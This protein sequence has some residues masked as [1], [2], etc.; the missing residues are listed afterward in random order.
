MTKPQQASGCDVFFSIKLQFKYR[1]QK[2]VAIVIL[3]LYFFQFLLLHDTILNC[4][5]FICPLLD[6]HFQELF[7]IKQGQNLA[8][9]A[10]S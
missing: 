5:G 10:C 7:L 3:N 9:L 8:R 2:L 4:M 6:P 1:I